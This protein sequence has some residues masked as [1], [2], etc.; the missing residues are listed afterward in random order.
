LKALVIGYGSI[1]KRHIQNL[2]NYPE[3]EIIVCTQRRFDNFLKKKNCKVI[4]SLEKCISENPDFAII[5]NETNLHL[6]TAKNLTNSGINFFTEKPLSNTSDGIQD[7]LNLV[8]R[9]NLV[10]MIG[11]NLRFNPCI[12]KIK[13]IVDNNEIGKVISV[14]VENGSYLPDWHPEEN[15][16][17]SYASRRT[18]GGG[19]VLTC[20][21]EI[22]YLYW[23]FGNVKEVLSI[24]GKFSDLDISAEDLSTIL[25]RFKNKVI[26]EIHLDYFQRPAF[27]S[28]K[29]I[30]TRGTI[31]WNSNKNQVKVFDSKK[32]KWITRVKLSNYDNNSMYIDEL[33]HF[34]DCLK[35]KKQ[36]MNSVFDGAKTLN[37]ALS[38]KK[39]SKAKKAI[40]I[41]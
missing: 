15:Y 32:G 19:V 21:H 9:K 26:A 13:G 27:R 38:I 11:C 2:S 16:S 12:K 40:T 30:G 36:T 34:L 18:L 24:T 20:I 14:R 17:E 22:D 39:A 3:I 4:K 8:R 37:I 28:F 33:S 35:K 31:Y 5:A 7:L 6:R 25:L 41:P 10:T 29:L 1:G 23:I